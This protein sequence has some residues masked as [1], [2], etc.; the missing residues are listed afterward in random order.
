MTV[1]TRKYPALRAGAWVCCIL[2]LIH[3][4]LLA[5]EA[6]GALP[7][8]AGGDPS[9]LGYQDAR[10]FMRKLERDFPAAVKVFTL[11]VNNAGVTIE[12]VAIGNGPVKNLVVATH[13]G[14]EY[15]STELAKGLAASLAADPIRGQTLYVIPV[16]NIGGYDAK[17]RYESVG[18]RSYDP[19][20]D[21]PGPCGTEGPFKLNSTR[22]LADFVAREQI[23]A[24]ATLHTFSPA[25]LYPWGISS[26][27]LKTPYNDLFISLG[28]AAAM[29]SGYQVGNSTEL[30]Y[31]ADGTFEDYAFWKHGMWSMLFEVGRSH[32]P[33]QPA[34]DEIVR[35]NVPGIRRMM[36]Q[37]PRQR[38]E[39]H[40]FTGKCDVHLRSLDRHDE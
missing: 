30:L 7:V 33:S 13:H 27:D 39:Q 15:G 23:V 19:N 34:V 22:A 40:D 32:S 20:R 12:G 26:H 38:A 17:R 28:Q 1:F 14:N 6:S 25:V 21:Y 18:G 9:R 31:P 3:C 37:A 8:G 10:D 2:F 29:E 36:E 16:L 35:T 5:G 4:G 11:G 24:S